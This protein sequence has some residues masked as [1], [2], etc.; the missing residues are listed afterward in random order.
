[1]SQPNRSE[2]AAAVQRASP[3]EVLSA[4]AVKWTT[5]ADECSCPDESRV[6]R[7]TAHAYSTAAELAEREGWTRTL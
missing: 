3:A 2:V 4:R 5:F 1:M 7:A 6:R